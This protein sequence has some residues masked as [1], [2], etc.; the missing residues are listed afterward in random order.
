MILARDNNLWSFLGGIQCYNKKYVTTR[1]SGAAEDTV[2]DNKDKHKLL[3]AYFG[4][5]K[6]NT[7]ED[8]SNKSLIKSSN[9]NNAT[10]KVPSTNHKN[11]SPSR[12]TSL[13]KLTFKKIQ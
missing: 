1:H 13:Q 3:E 8:E 11:A 7:K 5:T 10:P 4:W 9:N 6:D 12:T 2:N